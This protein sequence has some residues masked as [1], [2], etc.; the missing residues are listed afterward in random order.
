M[1]KSLGSKRKELSAEH[2]DE[3]TRIFGNF[4][5]VT[6]AGVPISRILERGLRIQDDHRR[7]AGA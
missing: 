2:I 7:A 1:R 4:R 6:K 3:I 5:K